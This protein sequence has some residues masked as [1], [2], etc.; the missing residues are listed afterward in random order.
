MKRIR[1]PA[2][3]AALLMLTGCSGYSIAPSE[4][5]SNESAFLDAWHQ[6]YPK[7]KDSDALN[8][9][10]SICKAFKAGT[11]YKDEVSR[12]I[13]L[14]SHVTPDDAGAMIG[15]ATTGFCPAYSTL[16]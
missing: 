6:R 16:R 3:L 5:S 2:A 7:D 13:T 11:S 4:P 9:A 8:V 1:G 12:L 10:K 14:G 15:M